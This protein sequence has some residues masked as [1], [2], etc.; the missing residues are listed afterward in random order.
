MK[1][2][3]RKIQSENDF[4]KIRAFLRKV[5]LLNDL[6]ERSWHV[7]RWDYWRWHGIENCGNDPLM[8][9][10]LI[11]E[12]LHGEIAAV[13]NPENR[14]CI[15]FQVHPQYRTGELESEMLAAAEKYLAFPNNEGKARLHLFAPEND[16]LRENLLGNHGYTLGT[17]VE[18]QNRRLISREVPEATIAAG[19][20]I[21]S[22]GDAS[23][24]PA[25]SW[26][27]F[28]G[29]HP[30]DPPENYEGWQWYLNVQRCPLYR[31]DL[32]MVAVAPDG[33][34]ASFCTI[35]YDDF[36]LTA[37]YE[38]VATPPEYQRKGLARACMMEGLRR[39]QKLGCV[40]AFIN[41]EE[42]AAQKFYH[43]I[44]FGEHEVNREW[45]KTINA[46][47]AI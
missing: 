44:G 38:P 22:L 43:T 26:A 30:K 9:S 4:W 46:E 13:V 24:L 8:E 7:A 39:L 32:D 14:N 37:Y 16:S 1:I 27:S 17:G 33:D 19:F 45:V 20:T 21:R 29:F 5:M 31:R 34:I 36:T 40:L 25:R 18:T 35:W 28:R 15:Y 6:R 10:I 3:M 41:S 2:K 42:P 23:E 11:W 12:T 47:L